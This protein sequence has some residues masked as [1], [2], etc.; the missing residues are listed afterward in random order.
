MAVNIFT[1][2]YRCSVNYHQ[3]PRR[4]KC[5]GLKHDGG[6]ETKKEKSNEILE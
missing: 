6:N 4:S 3:D 2:Q 1:S 5:T